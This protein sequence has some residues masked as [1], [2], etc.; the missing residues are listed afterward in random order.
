MGYELSANSVGKWQRY[1]GE[2]LTF[3]CPTWRSLTVEE[4]SS[5][6]LFHLLDFFILLQE[7]QVWCN[8]LCV[9]RVIIIHEGGWFQHMYPASTHYP[10]Q[11]F[12]SQRHVIGLYENTSQWLKSKTK[13]VV[14]LCLFWMIFHIDH[15]VLGFV[16]PMVG[17][18]YQKGIGILSHRVHTQLVHRILL[19]LGAEK[20]FSAFLSIL[21][22]PLPSPAHFFLCSYID[23]QFNPIVRTS[24]QLLLV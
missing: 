10:P 8:Y 22:V 20:W 11:G 9:L 2:H 24:I 7:I 6:F 1:R 5:I 23:M 4:R 12:K 15:R 18:M 17:Y 14:S 16:N 19:I 13:L 3:G 21:H